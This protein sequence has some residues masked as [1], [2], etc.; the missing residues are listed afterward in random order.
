MLLRRLSMLALLVLAGACATALPDPESSG[1]RLYATR[2][3]GCHRL[4]APRVLTGT[5][6]EM[7]VDR[8]QREMSV[9]GVAPLTAEERSVLLAYLKAHATDGPKLS[10]AARGGG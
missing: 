8:M 5:M 3:N 4:Y 2:C 9:R 1:A 10:P 7:Q 6:W